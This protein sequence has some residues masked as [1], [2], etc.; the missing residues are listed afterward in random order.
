MNDGAQRRGPAT[1]AY[2]IAAKILLIGEA[3]VG[4][5]HLILRYVDN[6]FEPQ[7]VKVTVQPDVKSKDLTVHDKKVRLRIWDTAG[8]ERFRAINRSFFRNALGVIVVYDVTDKNTF[9]KVKSWIEEVDVNC[10]KQP[11]VILVGNKTDL[12]DQRQ[13]STQEGR[14]LA[15]RHKMMFMEAS[16]KTR[17]NVNDV[18][19]ELSEKILENPELYDSAS[20][21]SQGVN[22]E[23]QDQNLVSWLTGTLS[24][25][26]NIL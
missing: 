15:K 14:E 21:R 3:G 9:A 11:V 2:D 12:A 26:C 1:P 8:S 10:D 5:T 7:L 22:L 4:K 20:R 24:S 13:V 16:A 23:H 17:E 25:M 19:F 18:F 6:I